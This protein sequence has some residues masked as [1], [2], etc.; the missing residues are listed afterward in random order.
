MNIMTIRQRRSMNMILVLSIITSFFILP[1]SP[2]RAGL[3]SNV[4]S[5]MRPLLSIAGRIGGAVAGASLAAGFCPPVGM[6]AG[7]IGGWIVGGMITDFASGSLTNLATLAGAAAG[8]MALGPSV[9]G[10][11][12]GFLLGGFLGKTA[13]GLIRSLDCKLT[14]GRLFDRGAKSSG[15]ALTPSAA[16]SVTTTN[17]MPV[18]SNQSKTPVVSAD[19]AIRDAQAKYQQAYQAYISATQGGDAANI[20]SANS[21]YLKAYAEYK[22]IV[23]CNPK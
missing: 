2:V 20:S 8:A 11:A 10:M 15:T 7:A 23:G 12:G 16:S 9:L 1:A 6:I 4:W 13:F 5:S 17:V 3:L 18:T 14:G 21:A 19:Q 22:V